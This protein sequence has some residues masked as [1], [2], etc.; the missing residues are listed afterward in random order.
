MKIISL[1]RRDWANKMAVWVKYLLPKPDHLSSTLRT[2]VVGGE[3]QLTGTQ[4]SDFHVLQWH[5]ATP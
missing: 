5:N 2:H 4:Y 3:N 1:L